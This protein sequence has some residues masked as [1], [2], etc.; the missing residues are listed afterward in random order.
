ML[1]DS[2]K[3]KLDKIIST[4][5]C[6][7]IKY[8]GINLNF[9]QTSKEA[10]FGGKMTASFKYWELNLNYIHVSYQPIERSGNKSL[11]VKYLL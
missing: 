1:R 8:W 9:N 3:A 4:N 10:N 7:E 2:D 6:F 5:F 11:S